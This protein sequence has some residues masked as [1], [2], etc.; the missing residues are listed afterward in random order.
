MHAKH[1]SRYFWW[2]K[3]DWPHRFHA[4]NKQEK[5]LRKTIFRGIFL[6]ECIK[7]VIL[8][9]M[10]HQTTADNM[11]HW[12]QGLM[13]EHPTCETW[14]HIDCQA[15]GESTYEHLGNSDVSWT[16]LVCDGP[17]YSTTLFDLHSLH[18]ENRYASLSNLTDLD[19]SDCS[20]L[21]FDS[22]ES[23]S[24]IWTLLCTNRNERYL[25]HPWL[26]PPIESRYSALTCLLE[27]KSVVEEVLNLHFD[28]IELVVVLKSLHVGK[29]FE[30]IF[31]NMPPPQ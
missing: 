27:L 15:V 26:V 29:Y 11:F 5:F 16:C 17:N 24:G 30:K 25:M 23:S 2:K 19:T 20:S 21:S 31:G 22:P 9:R 6:L 28:E 10:L 12:C 7:D 18:H 1:Q 14:Y 13:C 8:A 4:I 3:L